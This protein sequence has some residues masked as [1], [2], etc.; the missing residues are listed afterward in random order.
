[1]A[2]QVPTLSILGS[3]YWIL[4]K[5]SCKEIWEWPKNTHCDRKSGWKR[6]HGRSP[7]RWTDQIRTTLGSTIN[8]TLHTAKN[9]N[10]WGKNIREVM[11]K[12]GHDPQHWGN[13]SKDKI[14]VKQNIKVTS[15]IW[16][17]LSVQSVLS[18]PT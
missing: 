1:M 4:D 15:S 10:E 13:R 2:S 8:N 6:P 16:Y 11:Q 17:C 9:R 7:L 14:K 3:I 5:K 12:G 18:T